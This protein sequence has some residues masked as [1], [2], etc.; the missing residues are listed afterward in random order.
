MKTIKQIYEEYKIMPGLQLH[1]LRVASV[2]KI[3]CEN[4]DQKIDTEN[5]VLACLFHDM[6]N[7]IKS[8]LSR[9]PEFLEPQ[10]I[11]YWQKV[12]EEYIQ[13]YGADEH[14]ATQVIAQEIK[15]P[16]KAFEYLQRIGFS[17]LSKNELDL[18]LSFKICSYA[19]MR[20]GPYGVISIED[21]LI[22]GQK[23]YAGRLHTVNTGKFEPLAQS[24]RNIEEF[25]FQHCSLKPEEINDEEIK[26]IMEKLKT[27][28]V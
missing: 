10:G 1:Q 9:F 17:N 25:L 12:K 15:L 27:Y 3:I 13:K 6:G 28:D 5:I 26:G 24:L 19:D 8:E 22:D 21:R 14:K 23:R 2:A 20:V 16:T 11:E 18:E 7:I 4:F